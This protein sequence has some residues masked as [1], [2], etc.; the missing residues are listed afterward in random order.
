[1]RSAFLPSVAAIVL[2]LLLLTT[3]CRTDGK[4]SGPPVPASSDPEGEDLVQGAVVVA[5]EEPS[6][7][8]RLYKIK[9]VNFFPPPMGD[10]LV[11]IAFQETGNDFQHASDLWRKGDLSVAVPNARVQRTMFNKRDYRV[12]EVET[13]S[14][15]EEKLKA[16]DKLRP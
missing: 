6:Q 10:E 11:L 12:L 1:M 16:G 13:V 8:Y 7:S 4:G 5:F 2:P 14:E 9:K 15:R 3:A